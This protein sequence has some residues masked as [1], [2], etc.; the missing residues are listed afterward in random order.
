MTPPPRLA[1]AVVERVL[2]PK[3]R[4]AV[5]GDLDELYASEAAEHRRRAVWRYW[6]RAAGVVVRFG[7]HRERG[8]RRESPTGDSIMHAMW[9]DVVH[10]LRVFRA[11][12]GYA[13]AAAVTLALAI[14]A[15]TLIFTIANVLVLKPLPLAGADTL[16]WIFARGPVDTQW[17][18]PVSLPEYVVYR[19]SVDAFTTLSAYQR[20]PSTLSD[21]ERAERATA[22]VVIGDLHGLWDLRA[23]AGRPLSRADER[24]EA[25]AVVVLSHR[26]WRDRFAAR[27]DVVGL[28]LRLDGRD[29]TVVGVL[30]PDIELGNMA[31]IDVWMPFQ[32]EPTLAP[33]TDRSWRAVGRLRDDASIASAHAAVSAVAARIAAEHPDTDRGRTARVGPTRDALGTADTW[34]ILAMLSTVVGLLLILACANVMNLLIA[35]LIARRGELAVRAAL[36]ATRARLVRQIVV[37]S[38]VIGVAGAICGLVVARAGLAAVHAISYEPFFRQLTIDRT[39]I[40]FTAALAIVAPLLV[41]L[42]PT[43]RLLRHDP[44]TAVSGTATRSIGHRQTGRGQSAL[45]VLQVALAVALLGVA[46]LV[47][48]SMRAFTAQDVGYATT[49]LLSATVEVP[50]WHVTV[51]GD[52]ER[53][54]DRVMT[55]VAALPGSRGVAV[56]TL[57]P[58]L[59]SP[60]SIRYTIAGT[61]TDPAADRPLGAVTFVSE[62]FFSVFEVPLVAGRTFVPVSPAVAP[63]GEREVVLARAAARKLFGDEAAALGQH[64]RLEVRAGEPAV[65]A[66]VVGVAG[67]LTNLNLPANA[68]SQFY[69]PITATADRQWYLVVRTTTPEAMGDAVRRAVAAVDVELPVSDVQSV[70][71]AFHV[72]L[73]NNTLLSGLFA[74]FAM[75]AMLLA[76]AGLYGVLSYTVSRRTPEIAVRL[77]LGASTRQVAASVL[78]DSFKLTAVGVTIGVLAALGLAQAMRSTLYG[79]GPADPATYVFVVVLTTGAALLASWLPLRRALGIDPARG[80]RES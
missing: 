60:R 44:G 8:S 37:E 59:H 6:M 35:R 1:R 34:I 23:R 43:W 3:L 36:G 70:A 4:D 19:D 68:L 51:P 45:V 55:A 79:V 65:T 39:V 15:N 27:A 63:E 33:R 46:A 48:Q 10:S 67:D 32:D 54:R 58:G 21:G 41:A 24:P 5:V 47:V 17:R 62:S 74:A 61:P 73:S 22:Q 38:L 66:T 30:T 64:V 69:L 72:E 28:H 7:L 9:Q 11:Q 14:G 26:Y 49:P 2:G 12:P 20:R 78:G 77:A 42:V 50:E 40:G 31:E 16:G 80:V 25:P 57:I 71:H 29:R 18:G 76:T 53:L 56:T 75:V 52:A 13:I